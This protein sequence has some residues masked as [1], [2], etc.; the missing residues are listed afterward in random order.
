MP[1]W[2]VTSV[3]QQARIDDSGRVVPVHVVRYKV[4]DQGP[5]EMRIDSDKFTG[6]AVTQLLDEQARHIQALGLAT[7]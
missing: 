5:F 4:G 6:Q 1:A 7:S 2:T 3:K